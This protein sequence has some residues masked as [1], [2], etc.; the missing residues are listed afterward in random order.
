MLLR[1]INNEIWNWWKTNVF[2]LLIFMLIRIVFH[3]YNR[4]L[5][6][7]D[8]SILSY[9]KS[10][11]WGFRYDLMLIV[12]VNLPV[13]IAF[14]LSTAIRNSELLKRIIK[15]FSFIINFIVLSIAIADIPYFR[16]NSRR[17]TREV[18]DLLSDSASAFPSFFVHYFG[19]FVFTGISSWLLWRVILKRGG[20]KDRFGL[21]PSLI[22]LIIIA[23]ALNFGK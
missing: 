5:L 20:D 15:V 23:F 19:F 17:V 10:Y 22:S 3:I 11:F 21:V 16:F 4:D 6:L 14:M 13:L 18:F 9:M 2:L 12:C 1:R 7:I 8:D